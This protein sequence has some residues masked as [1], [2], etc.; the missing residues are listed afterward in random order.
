MTWLILGLAFWISA[1]MFKRA[2][3]QQRAAMGN[4]GR[5]VVAVAILAGIFLMV[6]GFR[7]AD[8]VV[9]YELPGW[10]WHLNNL[11]MLVAVFLMGVGKAGGVVGAKLR[12]PMLLGAVIW[13][14]AHLLVNGD[15]AS[16]VLFGALGLWALAEMAVINLA[17]GKWSP[18]VQ[19]TI[20]KD[21]VVAV[22][23]LVLFAAIAGVHYWIG[24]PVFAMPA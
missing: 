20:V 4:A 2:L 10:A 23:A 3:P 21:G 16:L 6:I 11:L 8:Y 19:G 14:V 24:Y 7:G 15:L 1:H 18:P 5:G 17:E 9:L 22:I 13:S 12:H